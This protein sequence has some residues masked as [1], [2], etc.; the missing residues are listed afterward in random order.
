MDYKKRFLAILPY[1]LGQPGCEAVDMLNHF[2]W[3]AHCIKSK[4]LSLSA[5]KPFQ[6]NTTHQFKKIFTLLG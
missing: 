2:R 1:I 5:L 6:I 4:K 3:A